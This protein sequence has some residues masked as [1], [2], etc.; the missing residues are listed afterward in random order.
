MAM[1]VLAKGGAGYLIGEGD[2]RE[3][4]MVPCSMASFE[5]GKIHPPVPFAQH[6]K[7][8]NFELCENDP[9]LLKKLMALP[10]VKVKGVPQ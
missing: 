10:K 2:P 8:A 6:L 5:T 4:V 3:N 9:V 7:F 1:R